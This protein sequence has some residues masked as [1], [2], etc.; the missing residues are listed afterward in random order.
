MN[1]SSGSGG[2]PALMHGSGKN[3]KKQMKMKII[4]LE[5]LLYQWNYTR[6]KLGLISFLLSSS[7]LLS[8][9]STSTTAT[10]TFDTSTINPHSVKI[11]SCSKPNHPK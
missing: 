6:S 2:N 7:S 4:I 9:I 8:R 11:C 5:Q 3:Q 10:D 1:Q